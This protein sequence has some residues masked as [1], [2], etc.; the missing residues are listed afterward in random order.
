[1]SRVSGCLWL[2]VALVLALVAGGAAFITLQKATA[3]QANGAA[4]V[5]TNP[6]VVAVHPMAV[7]SLLSDGDLTLAQLPANSTPMGALATIA[8]ATGQVTTV[9]LNTGEMVLSHHLTH[10]DVAA[11]NAAFTLP[12]GKIAVSL[13][14]DDLLS[15][16]ALIQAGDKVDIMYSLKVKKIASANGGGGSQQDDEQQYTF[17]TLQGATVVSLIR[18][19]L[20]EQTTTDTSGKAIASSGAPQAYIL[21]LPPQDALALKYLKDAGAVMDLG[22]RNITDETDHTAK[23]VDVRYIVDK[24]QLPVR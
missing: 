15:G 6:V 5:A 20:R 16:M 9:P 10:P 1:M 7:G 17:G 24:Y 4:P 12:E 22:L 18:S 13:S 11:D 14:A 3:N 23:P 8:E 21:A 19:A 2:S